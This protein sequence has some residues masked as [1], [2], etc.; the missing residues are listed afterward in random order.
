[1]NNINEN[2]NQI[3]EDFNNT[4]LDLAQ[5]VALIAP[6]SI[7]GNN[8]N[9][10]ETIMQKLNGEQ[11]CKFIDMFIVKVFLDYKQEIY[12]GDE[13]FFMKMNEDNFKDETEDKE[14]YINKLFEFQTLWKD[15]SRE[16]K[17][18]IKQYLVILCQ[19]AE[20]YVPLKYPEMVK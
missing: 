19:L 17:D 11:K 15:I 8:I 14:S 20:E 13:N 7:I 10:I 5:N 9:T 16:N 2:L 3:I 18:V 1:M 6:Y 4:L 12:D